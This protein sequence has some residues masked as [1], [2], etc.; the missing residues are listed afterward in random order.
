MKR[1]L[2]VALSTLLIH[3]SALAADQVVYGQLSSLYNQFPTGTQ[4]ASFERADAL[5]GIEHPA[6]DKVLIKESGTY[7]VMA[8]GQAGVDASANT[9]GG[10]V[11]LWLMKNGQ[12]V[13][14]S[15]VRQ[16][17]ENLQSTSVVV[18]QAILPMKEGDTISI[19]YS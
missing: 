17:L 15:G 8:A 14:N 19:G 18:S 10:V 7:F 11:D 5:V 2:Y 3:C 12:N 6:P 16:S 9:E 4:P 13:P 1:Y